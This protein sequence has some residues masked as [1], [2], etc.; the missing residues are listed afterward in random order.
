MSDAEY[1]TTRERSESGCPPYKGGE[2]MSLR[3]FTF[4]QAASDISRKRTSNA[5]PE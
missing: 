1:I 3:S 5:V 2:L 4:F